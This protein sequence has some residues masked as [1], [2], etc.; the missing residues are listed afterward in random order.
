MLLAGI[1]LKLGGF[2]LIRLFYMFNIA[3]I[4]RLILLLIVIN[5]V[6]GVFVRMICIVQV[7]LKKLIAYSSVRHIGLILSGLLSLSI[8]GLSGSVIM[9]VSHGFCSSG[10]FFIGNIYYERNKSRNLILFKGI[11][12]LFPVMRVYWLLLIFM[13]IGV[14]PFMN[15]MSEVLLIISV[16]KK[17]LVLV[18]FLGLAIML[19]VFFCLSL[20]LHFGHGLNIEY[21]VIQEDNFLDF[22]IV[23]VH[24]FFLFVYLLKVSFLVIF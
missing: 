13:N 19:T 24:L 14:P 3:G 10:L 7:D 21:S 18:F 11:I 16:L 1:L 9:M 23:N 8:I 17:S 6:G 22:F 20:F 2:G 4:S 5:I 15:F 12:R